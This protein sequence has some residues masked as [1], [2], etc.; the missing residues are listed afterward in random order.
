MPPVLRDKNPPLSFDQQRLWFLNQLEPNSSFYNVSSRLR[1]TGWLD[2]A[3]LLQSLNAIVCR[4]AVLR[5]TFTTLGGTPVQVI[6]PSLNLPLPVVDLSDRSETERGEEALRLAAAEAQ[7]LFDLAEGRCFATLIRLG[8]NDHVVVLTLHHIVCDGW[9]MGVLYHE[10]CVLYPAFS[11]GLP[12]PLPDLSIQY[13][14][15]AVWQREWLQGEALEFQLSYWKKQLEGAPTVINLPTDRSRPAVQSYRGAEQSIELSKELTG[16]LKMLSRKQSVTLFMTLL[17]A[18]QTLLHRYTG[19]H[20]IVV[21]SPIANRKRTEIEGLIGFFVNTL[22]LRSDLSGNPRFTELLARVREVALGAYAHQDLPF[23]KLVEEFQPERSLSHSPLFQVMF[24]LQNAPSRDLEL[25]GLTFDF[26]QIDSRTAKFDLLLSMSESAEGLKG[27]LEYRTDLFDAATIQRMLGHF[28][29]L[30]A[31][32]VTR[33]DQRL[34][35]LP[36]LTEVERQQLERWNETEREFPKDKCIHELFEEQVKKSPDALAVIFKDQQL[37]YTDLNRRANQLARYLKRLGVGPE[38][39]LHRAV[40]R[41]VIG[42]LG[43]LKAGG[44]LPLDPE[45]PTERLAFMLADTQ[46]SVLL[47]QKH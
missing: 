44:A 22:V 4:H 8:H 25:P 3:A 41:M 19:Q 1:L 7:N 37:S 26:M 31:G 29:T 15:F 32:I 14:D 36:I 42:L 11:K 46:A 21:G 13:A 33:P 9:S 2:V 12:S 39:G 16:A 17:A 6:S 47:T 45:Y 5:T 24:A 27:S 43:I 10:L 40:R 34:S 18:F 28:R 30:L 20:D 38:S 23:E 35:A